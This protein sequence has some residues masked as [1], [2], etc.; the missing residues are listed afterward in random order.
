MFVDIQFFVNTKSFQT[1]RKP[2]SFLCRTL[3]NLMFSPLLYCNSS[4]LYDMFCNEQLGMCSIQLL[5]LQCTIIG[6][7][8]SVRSLITHDKIPEKHMWLDLLNTSLGLLVTPW[9]DECAV[10]S[11]HRGLSGCWVSTLL[12]PL[13]LYLWDS[14]NIIITSHVLT[15]SSN[16]GGQLFTSWWIWKL[17]ENPGEAWMGSGTRHFLLDHIARASPVI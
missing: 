1:K 10:M 16:T 6:H 5:S 14:V 15:P 7:M 9:L 11:W 8:G 12:R 2:Y 17:I 3:L 4:N 13:L